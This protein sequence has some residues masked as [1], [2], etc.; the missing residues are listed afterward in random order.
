M[1]DYYTSFSCLLDVRSEANA[2]RALNMLSNYEADLDND[3]ECLGFE[4]EIDRSTVTGLW[5]HSGDYGEPGHVEEFVLRCAEAFKLKGHWGFAWAITCSKPQ[6]DAFGGGA[7]LLDLTTRKTV[8]CIDCRH[9]LDTQVERRSRR[10][11]KS[12]R[13]AK[14]G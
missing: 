11:P 10:P 5:I 14:A 4:M 13:R 12:K 6:L 1:P 2:I 9:W 8:A 3:G 7:V